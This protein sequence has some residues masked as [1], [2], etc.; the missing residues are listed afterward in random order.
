[1][2]IIEINTRIQHKH[3]LEINWLKATDFIPLAGELIY[4]KEVDA[5]GNVLLDT[6]DFI[7]S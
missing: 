3:D 1:M 4:D 2:A 7:I 5:A 6:L